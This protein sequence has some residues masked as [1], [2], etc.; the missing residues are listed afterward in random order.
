MYGY[1]LYYSELLFD[2]LAGC[3]DEEELPTSREIFIDF[4][5]NEFVF[6]I[7][8]EVTRYLFLQLEH[9][10]QYLQRNFPLFADAYFVN[11][12][13]YEL[14][15]A[16]DEHDPCFERYVLG[17]WIKRIRKLSGQATAIEFRKLVIVNRLL[18]RR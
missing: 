18:R 5:R 11:E 7:P 13:L 8:N 16:K 6:F 10:A 17:N 12:L 1:E 4:I 15:H 14:R 2:P 9:E 3:L